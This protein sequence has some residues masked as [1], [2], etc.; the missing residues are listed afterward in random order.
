MSIEWINETDEALESYEK[1][2]Q[3]VLET[4][5]NKLKINEDVSLS[6]VMVS[7]EKIQDMNRQWRGLDKSTDVLSFAYEEGE[8]FSFEERQLGDIIISVDHAR[9]QA[10]A[11]GHSLKR[12]LC[13]LFC[14]GLLHLLGYDHMTKEDE[15]VMFSLQEEILNEENITR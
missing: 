10:E 7:D 14:H 2:I 3:G 5:L 4:A 11:Y 12:E 6:V 1:D 13:F 8:N 15:K 9:E